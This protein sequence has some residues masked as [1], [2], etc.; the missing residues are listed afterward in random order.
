MSYQLLSLRHVKAKKRHKCI[1]CGQRTE[2]GDQYVR[3]FSMYCGDVQD[4]KWHSECYDDAQK[5]FSTGDV[6]FESF[7]NERPSKEIAA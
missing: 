1:W 4:H 5:Q 3:E 6:E 2:I 7:D